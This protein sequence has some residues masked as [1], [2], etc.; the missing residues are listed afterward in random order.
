MSEKQYELVCQSV[1]DIQDFM[2]NK[3]SALWNLKETSPRTVC[4]SLYLVINMLV[5]LLICN[6]FAVFLGNVF[7]IQSISLAWKNC[8]QYS[9]N[10]LFW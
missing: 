8:Q 7:I 5:Y 9:S 3:M 2:N 10:I 6:T 4:I 1:V